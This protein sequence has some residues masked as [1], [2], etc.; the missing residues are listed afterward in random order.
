[1][2]QNSDSHTGIQRYIALVEKQTGY[3]VK[4]IRSDNEG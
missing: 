3:K 4:I 2:K 1:M